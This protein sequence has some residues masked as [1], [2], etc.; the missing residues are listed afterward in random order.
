MGV[1]DSSAS[2]PVL[3]VIVPA[4]DHARPLKRLLDNLK[5]QKAPPGW[6]VEVIVAENGS[7]DDTAE[8]I[9]RSGF[10]RVESTGEGPGIARNAGVAGSRGSLLLFLDADACP[11]TDDFFLRVLDA[12]RK[13]GN[14][15]GFGGPILLSPEQSRNPVA[16][17]DHWA[18]WFNW[19]A[20]RPF[21]QSRLF[22]P[23]VCFAMK[24]DVFEHFGGFLCEALILE[25]MELEQRMMA[26][27]LPIYFVP[28]LDVTHWARGSPLRSW[29]HSWSWGGSFRE[30]YLAADK[31]YGLKYPV[32]D[33][34]FYR[35]LGYIFR[36]RMRIIRGNVQRSA[37][38]RDRVA[39]WF[40]NM[41]VFVWALAVVWGREPTRSRPI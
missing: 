3:S 21:M 32:G 5:T 7:R 30:R 1:P 33:P 31:S 12:A 28:G 13:L 41:T 15:G 38:W 26:A 4:R 34:R 29:R 37:S 16:S 18:C 22:Q 36:R 20:H 6:D 19:T 2:K 23:T 25:D 27:G 11:V 10:R 9:A 35:N 8:V 14:F 39:W 40:C 24:R 17:G